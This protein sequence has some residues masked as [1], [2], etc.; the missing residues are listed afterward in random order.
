[1]VRNGMGDDEGNSDG[2][3]RREGLVKYKMSDG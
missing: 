2:K 3:G 1:M